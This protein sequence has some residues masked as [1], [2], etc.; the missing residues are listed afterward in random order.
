[1]SAERIAWAV[2]AALLLNPVARADVFLAGEIRLSPGETP[3]S[4]ELSVSLPTGIAGDNA[5]AWPAGCTQTGF[6]RAVIGDREQLSYR[7][8]CERPPGRDD[9]VATRWKLDAAQLISGFSPASPARTLLPSVGGIRIPFDA[10]TAGDRGWRQL[11]P[12][13]LWQGM[14]HIGFGWDHLAFVLCL[15]MLAS[16]LPL[17]GLVTAFTLGHSLSLGLAFFDV[18]RIPVHPTEALIALSI[19]LVAR[20][21]LLAHAGAPSPRSTARAAVVVTIF[22]LV[23]GLGFAS[24]L[25]ELGI[26][27]GERWPTLLFFNL[28]I[29]LG[30]IGFVAVVLGLMNVLRP[31]RLDDAARRL[32]L[33]S[34]GIVGGFWLMERVAGFN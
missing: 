29:E 18:L 27:A 22:G 34:A 21:A 8:V 15:C 19:V 30:Q 17:L 11:A 33:Y 26:S 10:S 7:A 32:A 12:E 31:A 16:G 5:L 25:G 9:F 4:Y 6:Q 1:L 28:G 20:E 13:M 23:H 14:L 24:A 3:G 2:L